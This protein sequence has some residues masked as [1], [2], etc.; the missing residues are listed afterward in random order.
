MSGTEERFDGG[1]TGIAWRR[2][3]EGPPLLL[4]NGYAATKD[5]WDPTFLGGLAEKSTVICPDNRG[6]G[7]S[8]RHRLN[9]LAMT[10]LANCLD[11][12][13][14]GSRTRGNLGVCVNLSG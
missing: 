11:Q 2:L 3:G 10:T 4:V 7:Q 1:S 14:R 8:V 5:D 13:Q 6:V 12:W 9:E